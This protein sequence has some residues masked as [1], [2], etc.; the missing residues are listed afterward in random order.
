MIATVG[1]CRVSD[2]RLIESAEE[3]IV[4]V[5]NT[6]RVNVPEMVCVPSECGFISHATIIEYGKDGRIYWPC[7]VK[8]SLN[9]Q[10]PAQKENKTSQID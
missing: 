9:S 1:D 2:V 8:L 3:C 7:I 6:H 5:K 10:P 4:Q